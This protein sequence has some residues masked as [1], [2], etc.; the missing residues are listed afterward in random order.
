M[1]GQWIMSGQ[2]GNLMGQE[3]HLLV[4]STGHRHS[5]SWTNSQ[6]L[7]CKSDLYYTK[8]SWLFYRP[9]FLTGQKGDLSWSSKNFIAWYLCCLCAKGDVRKHA[10]IPVLL[11]S[12]NYFEPW[13]VWQN[14]CSRQRDW[15]IIVFCTFSPCLCLA[16]TVF[17]HAVFKLPNGCSKFGTIIK[18]K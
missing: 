4:M 14:F 16:I 12:K 13:C 7:T 2:K 18:K 15:M 6:F 17:S 5:H 9:I 8:F 10:S 11:P 1:A 3:L